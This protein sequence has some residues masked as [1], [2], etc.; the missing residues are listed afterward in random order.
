M[1]FRCL[2][3]GGGRHLNIGLVR[4]TVGFSFFLINS[5]LWW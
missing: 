1:Y 4:I 5:V 3:L 2:K